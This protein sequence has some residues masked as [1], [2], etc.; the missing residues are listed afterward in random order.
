MIPSVNAGKPVSPAS[1]AEPF[2][3][4]LVIRYLLGAGD[5]KSAVQY[6]SVVGSIAMTRGTGISSLPTEAEV[7]S[8]LEKYTG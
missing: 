1:A 2:F 8:F 7:I 4:A 6:G 3:A 5:I